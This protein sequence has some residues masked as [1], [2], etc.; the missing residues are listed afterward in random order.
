MH[1]SSG[2]PVTAPAAYSETPPPTRRKTR[3][4]PKTKGTVQPRK[5]RPQHTTKIGLAS[6]GGNRSICWAS[7]PAGVSRTMTFPITTQKTAASQPTPVATYTAVDVVRRTDCH[8]SITSP[9]TVRP[10]ASCSHLLPTATT[11]L[12]VDTA[13]SLGD[14]SCLS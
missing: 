13:A 5:N 11:D 3:L 6:S 10:I 4:T 12:V 8:L 7:L 14:R 2:A 9:P 1:G